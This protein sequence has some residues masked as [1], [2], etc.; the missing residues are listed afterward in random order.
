MIDSI[1]VVR[2]DGYE[3]SECFMDQ[4]LP[5][6]G[7]FRD[8]G[9]E[10]TLVNS[11]KGKTLVLGANLLPSVDIPEDSDLVLYNLEQIQVGSPWLTDRYVGLLQ[12][13]PVWDYS[14]SNVRALWDMG[15]IVDHVLPV[16]YH[17]SMTRI[18][19]KEPDID[20]LFYGSVNERR[21]EVLRELCDKGLRVTQ[22]F[23]LYGAERDDFVSRSRMVLN[24]HYYEAKVFEITRCSTLFANSVPV[25]S[26]TGFG[27]GDFVETGGFVPYGRLVD[28]CVDLL[29]D[30]ASLQA[31]G[32]R[33]YDIF[34]KTSLVEALRGV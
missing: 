6:Q 8:I 1:W 31:V 26:E 3:H 18:G 14:Q 17:S 10:V 29:A 32:Q 34:T 11:P 23:G 4:A 30:E 9:R 19:R 21:A 13:Y 24:M 20:V 22:A 2:P 7:A 16:A 5:I 25:V 15:I 33:G 28:H 12:K 27:D